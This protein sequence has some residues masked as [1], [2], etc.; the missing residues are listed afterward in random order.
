MTS[1]AEG[2]I[3]PSE[4]EA[5]P[6]HASTLTRAGRV[7]DCPSNNCF[8]LYLDQHVRINE[9]RK[10]HRRGRQRLTKH[11]AVRATDFG[12][13]LGFQHVHARANDVAWGCAEVAEGVDDDLETAFGL[14]VG[15][16]DVGDLAIGPD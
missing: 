2:R 7:T 9:S 15:V 5:A 4:E 8:R 13:I 16:T 12:P 3:A 10:H 6:D 14:E 11:L 1:S